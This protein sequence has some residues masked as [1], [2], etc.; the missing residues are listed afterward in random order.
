LDESKIK[1]NWSNEEDRLIIECV[2]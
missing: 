1:G 2:L